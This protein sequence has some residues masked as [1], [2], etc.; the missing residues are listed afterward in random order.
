MEK[1][2]KCHEYLIIIQLLQFTSNFLNFP[3]KNKNKNYVWLS[4]TS[5]RTDVYAPWKYV[6]KCEVWRFIGSDFTRRWREKVRIF[7]YI[8]PN[9]PFMIDRFD[10]HLWLEHKIFFQV[11]SSITTFTFVSFK[12]HEF[13]LTCD[14]QFPF[15]LLLAF[16]G[17]SF[18]FQDF[19]Y[20]LF[21]YFIFSVVYFIYSYFC[22]VT[23]ELLIKIF[24]QIA[25]KIRF[26]CES[27]SLRKFLPA[28][29]HTNKV[30]T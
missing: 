26:P 6:Q 3:R 30:H 24:G 21:Y 11:P 20:A 1:Y 13:R 23:R 12:I 10:D 22:E 28:A 15:N 16:F 9:P 18:P 17:C 19:L 8:S 14:S 2:A 5:A 27:L 25:K 29:L 7:K 4:L